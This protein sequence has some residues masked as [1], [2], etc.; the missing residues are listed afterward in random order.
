[1][2]GSGQEV[3]SEAKEGAV[4]LTTCMVVQEAGA[5]SQFFNQGVGKT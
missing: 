3:G 5:N 1:M 2:V 4:V